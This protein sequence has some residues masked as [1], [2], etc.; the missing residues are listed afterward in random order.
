MATEKTPYSDSIPKG[1]FEACD[2]SPAYSAVPMLCSGEIVAKEVARE[3][4]SLDSRSKLN[5]FS[6]AI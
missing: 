1:E 2:Y 5:E 6:K 3:A 4:G